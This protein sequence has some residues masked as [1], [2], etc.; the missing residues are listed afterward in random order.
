MGTAR[1][2][3]TMG[4]TMGTDGANTWEVYSPDYTSASMARVARVLVDG[5]VYHVTAQGFEADD[6]DWPL[7]RLALCTEG[8][9]FELLGWSLMPSHVH[10]LVRESRR[11]REPWEVYNPP[12]DACT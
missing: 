5:A 7:N 2:D 4:G 1:W 10:L 3:G 11:W 9:G 6:Y 8:F 12:L